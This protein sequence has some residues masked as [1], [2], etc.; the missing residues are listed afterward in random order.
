[1]KFNHMAIFKPSKI[2]L[3]KK[4]KANADYVFGT[5]LDAGSGGFNRYG[6]LF[7]KMTKY[8][9]LDIKSE[10][11]PDIVGPVDN[12]P[13]G[14]NSVDSIICTQVIGDVVNPDKVIK[15]FYRVVRPGGTVLLSESF[16]N[17]IHGEPFDYWRFTNYGMKHLF[18]TNGFTILKFEQIGGFFSVQAQNTIRYLIEKFKLNQGGFFSSIVSPFIN[19]FGKFLI[20][21]D[22]IDKSQANRKF[23]IGWLAIAKKNE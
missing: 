16:M 19:I 6:G 23:S 2:L 10:C 7:K 20:F 18:E 15:E 11:K 4:I 21:L 8:V 3:Y 13:L 22:K 17:E 9:S 1:M 5:T 14:D 12:I